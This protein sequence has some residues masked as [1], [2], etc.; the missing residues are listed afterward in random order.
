MAGD[1]IKQELNVIQRKMD[2]VAIKLMQLPVLMVAFGWEPTKACVTCTKDFIDDTMNIPIYIGNLSVNG[3]K[4]S[5]DSLNLNYDQNN[6]LIE[7]NA[8]YYKAISGV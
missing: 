1:S 8:L 2:C 3:A 5:T 7:F 4:H 6:L